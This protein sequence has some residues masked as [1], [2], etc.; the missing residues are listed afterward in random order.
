MNKRKHRAVR[1]TKNRSG[2]G[3]GG[4]L[5]RGLIQRGS[6]ALSPYRYRNRDTRS[7]LLTVPSAGCFRALV[8]PG[9]IEGSSCP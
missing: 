1:R 5:R 6:V 3:V 7:V 9:R 8:L 4:T 2:G